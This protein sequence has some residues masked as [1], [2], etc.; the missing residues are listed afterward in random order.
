MCLMNLNKTDLFSIEA[1]ANHK[2]VII[3]NYYFPHNL[4]QISVIVWS[5]YSASTSCALGVLMMQLCALYLRKHILSI[6]L[7]YEIPSH[8]NQGLPLNQIWIS[9]QIKQS[10]SINPQIFIPTCAFEC[11]HPP[12]TAPELICDSQPPTISFYQDACGRQSGRWSSF[13]V[14]AW[15]LSIWLSTINPWQAQNRT[16]RLIMHSFSHCHFPSSVRH[17]SFSH[18]LGA[19][20]RKT[21]TRK[22]HTFNS[23]K[24][25]VEQLWLLRG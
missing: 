16:S 24:F 23:S 8:W 1:I 3:F 4:L 13:H 7:H 22:N 14:D 20:E 21:N 15:N 11:T 18:Q 6:P 5:R 17:S 9:N 10:A 19:F 12:T 2:W 25:D